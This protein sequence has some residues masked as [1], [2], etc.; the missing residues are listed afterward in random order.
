M[1][2]ENRAHALHP[3]L[4]DEL[5]EV[6]FPDSADHSFR[7]T[8]YMTREVFE[9]YDELDAKW[10]ARCEKIMEFYA[11]HGPEDLSKEKFRSEHRYHT[12][13]KSGKESMI[14]AFKAY[15]VR[16]Y[17]GKIPDV[18]CFVCTEIDPAKKQDKADKTR[19]RRAARKLGRYI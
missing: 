8:I 4:L 9:T 12:G 15:Q 7:F 13:G 18:D 17:G 14:Y 10:R 5:V 6:E 1:S 19:L 3:S 16:L 2:K 11:R